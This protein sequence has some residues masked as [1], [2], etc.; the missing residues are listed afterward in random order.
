VYPMSAEEIER[1]VKAAG[2]VGWRWKETDGMVSADNLHPSAPLD[3]LYQYLLGCGLILP[4]TSS[5][6]Q[7]TDAARRP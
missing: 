6:R 7:N 2:L 5:E 4:R 1:Q 3:F